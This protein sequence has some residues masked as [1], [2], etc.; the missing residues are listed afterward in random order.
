[1]ANKQIQSITVIGAGQMGHQIAMLAALGGYETILQDVHENA[2]NA[3]KEKLDVILTKWVQK[4]KLSE[5]RKLAAFSRLQYTTDLEK[6]ASGADLIIEAV[7]EKLD[8][9]QEVFAKLEELAPAETIFAT[10]SSTIVNSLIAS[11]TNRP[12]KFI[13]M[14]FFFPPLVMDCVEVVMSDQTS[15]ET[16]KLAMEVTENMNRTGVL[17]RKEISGFVANRILGALQR[18]ALYL[19]EEGIVDYKDIDLI[20]RKALGHPIGPFELMDLS[21]I[22]V[23]YFVMQQRFNETGNQEDKPNACIEEKVNKGH[24][25]RKTGKGWYDYPN[26]GV[27][28]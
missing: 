6:A 22:D 11:V 15:E 1:M 8:V 23:G 13:N 21:G 4:G 3:A 18:E 14:H 28:N 24:L 2:L 16:A 12:D 9:K 25:G 26:Q 5:D 17:L 10:N 27:K 7:V 20:C 19:Y